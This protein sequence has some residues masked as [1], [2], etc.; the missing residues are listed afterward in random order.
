MSISPILTRR[1]MPDGPGIGRIPAGVPSVGIGVI[2]VSGEVDVHTLPDLERRLDAG[3][4]AAEYGLVVD[5]S[6]VTFLAVSA[7]E[8]LTRVHW[9]AGCAGV[10]VVLVGGPH[11][12]ERAL[13]VTG[14][15]KQFHCFTSPKRAFEACESR[16]RWSL[17]LVVPTQ[18]HCSAAGVN[19]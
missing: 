8:A 15:D 14:A 17:S 6:R 7:I 11:C 3:A 5:L 13:S 18:I 9:R 4:N 10:D 16:Y 2:E 12:V 19:C 1:P